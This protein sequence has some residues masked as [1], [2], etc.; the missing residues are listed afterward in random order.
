MEFDRAR[1]E[2]AAQSSSF[3]RPLDQKSS[4]STGSYSWPRA[5]RSDTDGA[6]STFSGGA[7]F[8]RPETT[9][10][11]AHSFSAAERFPLTVAN[12]AF[13]GDLEPARADSLVRT[14]H[15]T[16]GFGADRTPR[17]L[18]QKLPSWQTD[19]PPL[20]PNLAATRPRAP[21][22]TLRG[23]D[24]P[25][26]RAGDAP[27]PGKYE[28][29]L[30]YVKPQAPSMSFAPPPGVSA[31][32]LRK[33]RD[34]EARE[35]YDSASLASTEDYERPR[36]L[37]L[38]RRAPFASS[39]PRA[40][41]RPVEVDERPFGAEVPMLCVRRA[42]PAYS[43]GGP[44]DDGRDALRHRPA[45]ERFGSSA[46]NSVASDGD[47]GE[48]VYHPERSYH[49]VERRAPAIGFGTLPARPPPPPAE[50][51]LTTP[52][53][54]RTASPPRAT[55]GGTFGKAP[56]RGSFDNEPYRVPPSPAR[57]A[58]ASTDLS[59]AATDIAPLADLDVVRPRITGGRI[60]PPSTTKARR[61]AGAKS[62]TP[63]HSP[64]PHALAS[65]STA[66]SAPE[67]PASQV[68]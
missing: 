45:A 26:V 58:A 41:D 24:A 18:E 38:Q 28:P 37:E 46:G 27:G 34:D 57:S 39:A 53:T 4:L 14:R 15:A 50:P 62:I 19:R 66:Q 3:D 12:A 51:P 44:D 54:S 35:E 32:E 16:S 17:E 49:A 29:S 31:V 8:Y 20:E 43:F 5:S 21:V 67:K 48:A 30:A 36:D 23:R 42:A 55:K 25:P 40:V 56:R 47:G 9:S 33:R 65:V 2:P 6:V 13:D 64:G 11:A 68:Q 52:P 63:W 60:L 59:D 22:A 61:D 7:Q 1:R 10:T